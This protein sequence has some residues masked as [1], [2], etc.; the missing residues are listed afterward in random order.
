MS[1]LLEIQEGTYVGGLVEA[2]VPVKCADGIDILLGEVEA[3]DI[4]VGLHDGGAGGLGDNS[5]ATLGSPSKEDLRWGLS[6]LLGNSLNGV[7][8]E[9]R[10]EALGLLHGELLKGEGTEGRVGRDGDTLSL[11]EVDE[12]L[13]DEVRVMLDLEGGGANLGVSEE[14]VKE[15]GLEVGDADALGEALLY[16][17][18]EGRPGL[19]DGGLGSPN[20]ALAVI[21]PAGRV[22]DA[23]VDVFKGNGEV[24]EVEVKVVEA[25]VGELLPG[26]G[27]NAVAV[28]EGVPE[29]GD[30]EELL[31][32]HE[33]VG[34]GAGDTLAALNL[35]AIV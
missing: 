6:V 2:E 8:L 22:A 26:D 27:L 1:R 34:D 35:V 10:S 18:L 33:T 12:L 14:V 20:L 11:G 16:E 21:K 29:L 30:D 19:L 4:E 7:L 28:V 24:D 23:G 5:E 13:L 9:E 17:A 3:R 25:P 15:L 31:A 32:L